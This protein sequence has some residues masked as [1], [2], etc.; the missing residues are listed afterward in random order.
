M[1]TK[2]LTIVEV[3]SK[4]LGNIKIENV[5]SY[6]FIKD[7]IGVVSMTDKERVVD[8]F[9]LKDVIEFTTIGKITEIKDIIPVTI[10]VTLNDGNT[11]KIPDVVNTTM[12]DYGYLVFS[13]YNNFEEDNSIT[14]LDRHIFEEKVIRIKTVQDISKSAKSETSEPEKKDC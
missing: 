4:T 6:D 8:T 5:V 11:I 10:E 12:N 9:Y 3:L 13:Q 1:E 7:A 14:T 2:K